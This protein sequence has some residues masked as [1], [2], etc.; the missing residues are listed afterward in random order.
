M[1]LRT[2]TVMFCSQRALGGTRRNWD[3][4][5]VDAMTQLKSLQPLG[6]LFKHIGTRESLRVL[7]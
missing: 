5:L 2:E 1:T 7:V 3:L 6:L 4:S